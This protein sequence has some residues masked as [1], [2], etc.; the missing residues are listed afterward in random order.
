MPIPPLNIKDPE[1]YQLASLIAKHTGKTLTRVVIDALRAEKERVLPRQVDIEKVHEILARID[2]MPV[3]DPRPPD[4]ILTGF[5]DDQGM[6][7]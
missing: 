4:E 6:W 3:R 1:A 2:A 7:K 5:Y